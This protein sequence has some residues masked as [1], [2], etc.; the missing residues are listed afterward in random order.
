MTS[1]EKGDDDISSIISSNM[2]DDETASVSL[3]SSI[4]DDTES[5]CSSI[6]SSSESVISP[7]ATKEKKPR[8]RPKK[9]VPKPVDVSNIQRRKPGRPRRQQGG[10]KSADQLGPLDSFFKKLAVSFPTNPPSPSSKKKQ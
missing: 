4:A 9:H 5:I 10:Q 6:Q 3:A 1:S 8:G 2:E 7:S